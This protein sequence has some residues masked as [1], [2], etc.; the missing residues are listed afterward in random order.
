MSALWKGDSFRQVAPGHDFQ[1]SQECIIYK[2][3][4]PPAQF[5]PLL[6]FLIKHHTLQVPEPS[7]KLL[8]HD[9]HKIIINGGAEA[10]SLPV[11]IFEV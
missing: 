11:C 7:A 9:L 6:P 2:S 4:W 5:H 3:K 1:T 10:D 8:L